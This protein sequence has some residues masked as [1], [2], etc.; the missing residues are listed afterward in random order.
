MRE[1][2]PLRSCQGSASASL[3][4]TVMTPPDAPHESCVENASRLTSMH[5][6]GGYATL[7]GVTVL[8]TKLPAKLQ[9]PVL[10]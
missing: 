9:I 6:A 1:S 8:T 4:R 10:M 7:K 3:K 5:M 2:P